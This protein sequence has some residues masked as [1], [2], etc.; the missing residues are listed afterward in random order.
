MRQNYLNESL[1]AMCG[2]CCCRRMPGALS[3]EDALHLTGQDNI[4]D[5]L[6]VLLSTGDYQVDWWEGDPRPDGELEQAFYLRP[7]VLDHRRT[8]LYSPSWGG[9]CIFLSETGC[10]LAPEDRPAE[11][12]LLEPKEDGNCDSGFTKQDAAIAWIP[13]HDNIHLAAK[14]LRRGD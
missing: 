14:T 6:R 7:T 10:R 4:F 11:C 12:R 5:A 2:G 1:C 8:R 13:Y 9:T 3:P